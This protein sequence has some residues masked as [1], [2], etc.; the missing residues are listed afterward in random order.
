MTET[1]LSQ[2]YFRDYDP[3]V[4]RYVE[5]DPIGLDGGINTYA[6]VSDNPVAMIDP[7]G[8]YEVKGGVPAPSPEINRLLTCIE[9]CYGHSFTVTSTTDYHEPDTPHDRGLAADIRY[10]AYP[11]KFLCCAGKCGAGFALDEKLHP[12]TRATAPHIH[13][14]IPPGKRGGRGDLPSDYSACSPMA[15]AK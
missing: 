2:N 8:Q 11:S 3:M 1:G 13:V 5:S 12:S 14:Q 6:Y 4:G 15:C 10:P 9:G 7:R